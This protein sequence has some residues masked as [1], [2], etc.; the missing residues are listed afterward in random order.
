MFFDMSG[1]AALSDI[2]E[3]ELTLFETTDD[4]TESVPENSEENQG[5]DG[6]D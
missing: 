3:L 4:P 6:N 1:P 5:Q 2:L